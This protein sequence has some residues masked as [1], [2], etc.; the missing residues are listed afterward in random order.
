CAPKMFSP[1]C[2]ISQCLDP[3]GATSA[4]STKLLEYRPRCTWH[5]APC[6]KATTILVLA[7]WSIQSPPRAL[8]AHSSAVFEELHLH[9]PIERLSRAPAGRSRIPCAFTLSS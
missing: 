1:N 2:C 4:F 8:M 6:S 3:E 9:G 7:H 5:H